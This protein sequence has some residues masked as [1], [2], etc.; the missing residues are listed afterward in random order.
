MRS[1]F[2]FTVILA[3]F[4]FGALVAGYQYLSSWQS[5]PIKLTGEVI[6][7]LSPGMPL[8]QLSQQLENKNAITSADLFSVWMKLSR[9]YPTLQAGTYQ[10][11][12]EISPKGILEKMKKGDIYIPVVLQVT[13]PEGF[14]LQ[15]LNNR[16][17]TKG[18][19]KLKDIQRLVK[20]Q[21]FIRSLGIKSTS[22]EGYTYHHRL[23]IERKAEA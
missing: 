22:L 2:K 1:L 13:I 23:P 14:T 6:I 5:D 21:K 19:G 10:F 11:R 12:G 3:L 15:M 8:R 18:V 9:E 20:D 7:E 4:A 17:A 16:L